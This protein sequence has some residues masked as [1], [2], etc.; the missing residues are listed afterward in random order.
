MSLTRAALILLCSCGARTELGA[1]ERDASV[2]EAAIDAHEE[3]SCDF[4]CTF[5]HQCCA[6]S[7]SG[8]PVPMPNDCCL[9][10]LKSS[11]HCSLTGRA[12]PG[13]G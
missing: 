1:P 8:P 11:P 9:C 4:E 13:I 10:L 6:G 2:V 3:R 12:S 7:C 5:G